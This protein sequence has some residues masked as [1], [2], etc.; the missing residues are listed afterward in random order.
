MVTARSTD[1]ANKPAAQTWR[2]NFPE[3]TLNL[4][5]VLE[6]LNNRY[7]GESRGY[8]NRSTPIEYRFA[9]AKNEKLIYGVRVRGNQGHVQIRFQLLRPGM[10]T[11]FTSKILADRDGNLTNHVVDINVFPESSLEELSSFIDLTATFSGYARTSKLPLG[12]ATIPV[13]DPRLDMASVEAETV[14]DPHSEHEGKILTLRAATIRLGQQDF[15]EKLLRHYGGTCFIS[16]CSVERVLEAAHIT[17]YDGPST[18]KVGNGLLLRA[19]LHTLWD[20]GLL[21][22]DLKTFKV[23]IAKDARVPCYEALHGKTIDKSLLAGA[24]LALKKHW[25]DIAK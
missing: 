16:E 13:L 12:Q 20:R 23:W 9:N 21:A 2:E 1:L 3:A 24:K 22:I 6:F 17:H 4:D 5:R 10:R 8:I 18:N 15:R 25:D 14:Y 11:P 7:V 19:D